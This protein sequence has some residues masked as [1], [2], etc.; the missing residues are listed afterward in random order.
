MAREYSFWEK[1]SDTYA[2]V[3]STH[4]LN[5]LP[6]MYLQSLVDVPHG[7]DHSKETT[8]LGTLDVKDAFLM[9]DQ[10]SP[11]LVTLLGQTFA[12]TAIG[13]TQLVLVPTGFPYN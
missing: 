2:P 6:M 7:G 4:I 5:L 3:T 13:R 1:R 11:M 12:R 10:P 8:C 9:V